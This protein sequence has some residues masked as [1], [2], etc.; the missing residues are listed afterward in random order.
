MIKLIL[1]N[2]IVQATGKKNAILALTEIL[3]FKV[4]GVEHSPLYNRKKKDGTRIWDGR[5]K[6]L[7]HIDYQGKGLLV[8]YF[9][10][11][12]LNHVKENYHSELR[13]ID[14]RNYTLKFN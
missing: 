13:I 6:F 14:K 7:K 9:G 5:Y 4:D 3:S 11:G 8:G 12:L 2:N 1:G 10:L